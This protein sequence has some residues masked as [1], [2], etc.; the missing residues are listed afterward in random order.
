MLRLD[1]FRDAGCMGGMQSARG[2]L[3]DV[4]RSKTGGEGSERTR[5]RRVCNR[6]KDVA[7]Q[8]C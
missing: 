5:V 7:S 3:A 2:R 8:A 1:R 4:G 6:K